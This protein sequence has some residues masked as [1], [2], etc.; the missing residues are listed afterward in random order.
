MEDKEGYDIVSR[1]CPS[2]YKCAQGPMDIE[3][4]EMQLSGYM[5]QAEEEEQEE[6]W[7]WSL[8]D[9]IEYMVMKLH[10]DPINILKVMHLM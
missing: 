4:R 2:G 7:E 10:V 5:C 1:Q 8:K 6:E 3:F 9:T